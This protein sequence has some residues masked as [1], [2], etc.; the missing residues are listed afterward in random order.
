MIAQKNACGCH[1][2]ALADAAMATI[3]RKSKP[4]LWPRAGIMSRYPRKAYRMVTLCLGA[5]MLLAIGQAAAAS[6]ATAAA[7]SSPAAEPTPADAAERIALGQ[8]MNGLHALGLPW[9]LQATYEWFGP[10]GHTKDKGTFEEWN[11]GANQYRIALRSPELSLDEYR[12]DHGVFHAGGQAWP[13]MPIS[14]IPGLIAAPLPAQTDLEY[15]E[16]KNYQR[17]FGA[18]KMPCTA[19]MPEDAKSSE[20]DANSYCFAPA[21]G[22]V[23]YAS[24]AERIYQTLFD[25]FML[26]RRR[27]LARD[28]HMFVGGSPWLNVHIDKVEAL[29]PAALAI[30][31]P[32]TDAV[33]V[34][35]R[36]YEQGSITAGRLLKKQI[37]TYPLGARTMGVQGVVLV[38]CIVDKT[39][40]PTDVSVLTGPVTL[41][42]AAVEAVRGWRWSPYS[43][44]GEPV[45]VE[46]LIHVVFQLGR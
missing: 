28:M 19:L 32:P 2:V 25:H 20:E 8:A 44:Q 45:E 37:P 39:G 24:S 11:N 18:G 4:V 10:D 31:Q 12:T 23:F 30:L 15:K 9:H 27:Y 14:A 1:G 36:I 21:N 16:L 38:S 3:P 35:T 43:H 26:V 6:P 29:A 40:H 22:V 46:T 34:P 17:D 7:A 41:Q 13:R 5:S 42:D 33:P